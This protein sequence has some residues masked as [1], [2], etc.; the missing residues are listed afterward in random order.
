MT[1]D[2]DWSGNYTDILE[3]KSKKKN[4]KSKNRR[5]PSKLEEWEKEEQSLFR[6]MD[7]AYRSINDRPK[8][9]C[10]IPQLPEPKKV[11]NPVLLTSSDTPKKKKKKSRKKAPVEKQA[12]VE[13]EV[14][15]E[16]PQQEVSVKAKVKK[17]K[18]AK[19]PKAS[20]SSGPSDGRLIPIVKRTKRVRK[21][22]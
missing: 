22:S 15:V 7:S 5:N 1:K 16:E 3:G 14:R 8:F 17:P 10:D 21:I 2:P 18:A 9:K 12:Q 4:S 20:K 11:R 19:K 13:A 6:A